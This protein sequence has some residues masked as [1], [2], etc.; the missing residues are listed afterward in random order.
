MI[1]LLMNLSVLSVTQQEGKN[2]LPHLQDRPV[3]TQ[4]KSF[5]LQSDGDQCLPHVLLLLTFLS[6]LVVFFWQAWNWDHDSEH[7]SEFSLVSTYYYCDVL[8][9]R[10]QT[11]MVHVSVAASSSRSQL[12]YI[13]YTLAKLEHFWLTLIFV[14]W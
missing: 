7:R 6:A 1:S 8:L 10:K 3:E 2:V 9:I 13:L 11:T 5:H 12:S 4:E 14:A